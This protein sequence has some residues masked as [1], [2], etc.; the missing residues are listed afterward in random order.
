[1]DGLFFEKT[2]IELNKN[3]QTQIK[4]KISKAKNFLEIEKEYAKNYNSVIIEKLC[5]ILLKKANKQYIVALKKLKKDT[6]ELVKNLKIIT[7]Y[8]F[9]EFT[10]EEIFVFFNNRYENFMQHAFE[11]IKDLCNIAQES[12]YLCVINAVEYTVELFEN[13]IT[14]FLDKEIQNL[15]KIVKEQTNNGGEKLC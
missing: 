7:K 4:E 9:L 15:E 10:E 5:K 13:Q 8:N 3:L 11:Y 1:M 6:E 2:Q 14:T 12:G